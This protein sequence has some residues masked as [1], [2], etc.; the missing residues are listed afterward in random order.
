MSRPPWLQYLSESELHG[1]RL[2]EHTYNM[3]RQYSCCGRWYIECVVWR[4]KD[5]IKLLHVRMNVRYQNLTSEPSDTI[6]QLWSLSLAKQ[7]DLCITV[8]WH[9]IHI[10]LSLHGTYVR[11]KVQLMCGAPS[12]YVGSREEV[13]F[14][15][16]QIA[17]RLEVK[18]SA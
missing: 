16:V 18:A 2:F 4:A 3:E 9:V 12:T 6:T 8:K 14:C 7:R 10:A 1:G 5:A 11:S 13:M 17:G 15:G